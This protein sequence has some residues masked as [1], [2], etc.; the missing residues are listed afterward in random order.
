[1]N[2]MM[3]TSNQTVRNYTRG[4][5]LNILEQ[6]KLLTKI[7]FDNEQNIVMQVQEWHEY[8]KPIYD[9]AIPEVLKAIDELQEAWRNYICTSF[10]CAWRHVYCYKYFKLLKILLD[11]YMK[12]N[13][14]QYM[15]AL[16]RLLGLEC[17]E[18]L[19]SSNKDSFTAAGTSTLRNACYLLTKLKNPNTLDDCQLL[20]LIT[21]SGNGSRKLFY[22]YRQHRLS[23]DSKHSLLLYLC[24]SQ[25]ARPTSFQVVNQFERNI[26]NGFDPRADERA[27]RIAQKVIIPYLANSIFQTINS[28]DI[29]NEFELIDLGSG[30]GKLAIGI[31]QN[32]K[33]FY[34][35]RG[36]KP[37]LRLWLI[38][39]SL[40]D[41][42]R[43]LVGCK[44]SQFMDCLNSIG[45]NY[46][47]WI[48]TDFCLPKRKGIRFGLASRFFNSFSE[49]KIDSIG[50]DS[51]MRLRKEDAFSDNWKKC[52]PTICLRP[53]K[54]NAKEL[55]VSNKRIWF[56]NGRSFM[57]PSL[58][59]Y[60]MA[61]N[62]V[63]ASDF[64]RNKTCEQKEG[65]FL[66]I[67]S[68]NQECL[69]SKLGHSV[70]E[71]LFND[72]QMIFIQMR[73]SD[74]EI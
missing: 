53:E 44:M 70:L 26:G 36:I 15:Q 58:T 60:F 1:M 57:Q 71:K 66:P 51:L 4:K 52:L 43:T 46:R 2:K 67:R 49:F 7:Y 28:S 59:Q 41:P 9:N 61:L 11:L 17:F 74:R 54:P 10:N 45:V 34:L 16:N 6:D 35:L 13:E 33:H 63:C 73:I 8:W 27:Q 50:K 30:S 56:E 22:H 69:K 55:V 20:P 64:E 31:C 37:L 39:L 12:D 23:I 38:D 3:V 68:F 32:I 48:D 21:I 65:I 5:L 62:I 14:A 72:C 29:I 19:L 25:D 24:T 40:S 42:D 18:I 47:S